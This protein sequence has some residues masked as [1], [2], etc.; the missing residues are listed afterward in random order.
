G[1][2][3][4]YDTSDWSVLL[5]TTVDG[6]IY[7]IAFD[8]KARDLLIASEGGHVRAEALDTRRTLPWRDVPAAARDVAYGPDGE[9]IGFVWAG[10]G[11]WFYAV[12]DDA[13]VYVRDHFSSATS[14][15][16]SPDGK[17]FATSDRRGN[18]TLRDVAATFA[19]A[20]S[21]SNPTRNGGK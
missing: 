17:W 7:R 18:V 6:G 5:A 15:A 13:W 11:A 4:V 10:G 20:P 3:A 8:P 21:A 12:R 9:T 1:N 14:G 19:A 2:V 16:F